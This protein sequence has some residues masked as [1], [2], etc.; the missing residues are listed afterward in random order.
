MRLT[1]AS[2]LSSGIKLKLERVNGVF[3][4]R[5]KTNDREIVLIV[6]GV[7]TNRHVFFFPF[8]LNF[9]ILLLTHLHFDVIWR[10]V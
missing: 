7:K 4:W 8:K 9:R 5:L 10:I 2:G 6:A 3:N 1:V